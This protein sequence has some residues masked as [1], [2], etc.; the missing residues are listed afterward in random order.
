MRQHKY[1][2]HL[3]WTIIILMAAVS[4]LPVLAVGISAYKIA[5]DTIQDEVKSVSQE[6]VEQQYIKIKQTQQ[7]AYALLVA[8]GD[9]SEIKNYFYD[10]SSNYSST[11][12]QSPGN[13]FR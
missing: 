1:H 5:T 8:L 9:N 10:T 4:I 7:K 6:F 13:N 3:N 2:L 12:D 11:A